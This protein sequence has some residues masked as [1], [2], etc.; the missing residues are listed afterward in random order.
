MAYSNENSNI[1]GYSFEEYN[2]QLFVGGVFNSIGDAEGANIAFLDTSTNT[3]ESKDLGLYAD[4]R[5]AVK[6]LNNISN[7]LWIGGSFFETN[8]VI[9]NIASCDGNDLT[10]R[11]EIDES[12][13]NGLK[14]FGWSLQEFNG[15]LIISGFGT[16]NSNYGH[17]SKLSSST[18]DIEPFW[19][20]VSHYYTNDFE[21][22]DGALYAGG[23]T[24][25]NQGFIAYTDQQEE[26]K[27]VNE[28]LDRPVDGLANVND[29]LVVT[30]SFTK[31]ITSD[32][33]LG[34][35]AKY[36][37]LNDEY[38]HFGEGLGSSNKVNDV[39]YLNGNIYA[40]GVN[41]NFENSFVEGTPVGKFNVQKQI[42]EGFGE[43]LLDHIYHEVNDL[44]EYDEL[45]VVAG[46][47]I[48]QNNDLDIPTAVAYY[49]DQ[50]DTWIRLG[51]GIYGT[52]N[53]LAVYNNV[54]YAGGFFDL[55]SVDGVNIAFLDELDQIWKPLGSGVDDI[56]FDLE[57]FD[58]KLYIVGNFKTAG[59]KAA[60]GITYYQD[61]NLVSNSMEIGKPS[62]FQLHQNYPN[63]FNPS[64]IISFSIPEASHINL[65]I[66]DFLG[67]KVTELADQWFELGT[68]SLIFDASTI[69]SGTY[70]YRLDTG[71]QVQTRKMMLIK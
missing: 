47:N 18:G 50:I 44:I 51:E 60:S 19:L 35:I 58:G 31:T 2:E 1:L 45:L 68:H 22:I 57:I 28:K 36:D 7:E 37:F 48:V 17:I 6:S 70:I 30:G 69:S 56:V 23:S 21:V 62:N 8:P 20:S 29:E 12:L 53:K 55:D 63:P 10:S 11:V 25:E 14:H 42:W 13:K 41:F 54:L 24:K 39:F 43:G 64:T 15:E 4:G 71:N 49:H 33:P 27:I 32:T 67:R 16:P 66:Y 52:V 61:P 34:S 38:I 9:R 5:S 40:V 3:W 59:G 26:W 65:A 46:R